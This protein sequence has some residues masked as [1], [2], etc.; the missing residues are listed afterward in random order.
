MKVVAFESHGGPEVLQYMDVPEPEIGPNDVLVKVK[1]AAAN[2][3]DIWARRG[4]PGVEITM[5]HVSGSDASGVVEAVGSEVRDIK[6]G[7]EVIVH[8][9]LSCRVCEMCTS[10]QEFF[11]RR[12]RIW[13]FQTGPLDGG[14]AEYARLPAINVAPKPQG[15]SFEEASSLPLVLMTAWRMLVSR[16]RI[17]PGEFVL[18]WGAG[19]GLGSMA[20]QICRLF[21]AKAM[22]VASSDEKL[23][24]CEEL[25]ATHLINRTKQDV[26]QET[27]SITNR[28]GVDVVF[29]HTGQ[30]T[31][32]TSVRVL[33]W[34]GTIVVCGATTGHEATTDLRFLWNKQMNFYGSHMAIKSE[35]LQALEFVSEGEIKPLIYRVLSLREVAQGQ[36]IM[37]RDEVIG[38]IV[39]VPE[40]V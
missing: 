25:G 31:W 19:G 16:A 33:R 20:I 5:P 28:R 1:A 37:E 17:Q 13:G 12:F 39:Y 34:G 29:E 2:Y 26:Y 30:A 36:K 9:S 35:L 24:K 11:C 4:L 27:R 3:N 21:R 38:K 23:K 14:H 18:I 7:D 15:I 40:G 22:A 32:P 8:P 10:G 6:Q